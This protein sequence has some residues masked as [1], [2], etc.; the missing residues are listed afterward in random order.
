MVLSLHSVC[1]LPQYET[2]TVI[3]WHYLQVQ[4]VNS[5]T[6]TALANLLSNRLQGNA[7]PEPSNQG[8]SPTTTAAVT[9]SPPQ[10]QIMCPPPPP[11][12]SQSPHQTLSPQHVPQA[13]QQN[14]ILQRRSLTTINTNQKP[15]PVSPGGRIIGT[16]RP[17]APGS[18]RAQFYGHEPNIKS[19]FSF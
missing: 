9:P 15:I 7:V 3:C 18:A 10:A 11:A 19:K 4:V 2:V 14:V 8:V 5:K 17:V 13:I 1:H 12:T 6:K 16:D